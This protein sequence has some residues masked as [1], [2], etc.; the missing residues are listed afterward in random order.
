M[1]WG[2]F[3]AVLISALL[4]VLCALWGEGFWGLVLL[5]GLR[6]VLESLFYLAVVRPSFMVKGKSKDRYRLLHFGGGVVGSG[7]LNSFYQ[8]IDD[9]LGT[10]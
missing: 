10:K 2:E 9:I 4:G 5:R 6:G 7:F 3:G 1:A 8:N